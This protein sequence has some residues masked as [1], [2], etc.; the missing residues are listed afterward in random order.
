MEPGTDCT[1]NSERKNKELRGESWPAVEG[2]RWRY[3]GVIN[4]LSSE[5][6]GLVPHLCVSDRY[7]STVGLKER[8][9]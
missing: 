8:E 3:K 4:M 2:L 1:E 9:Q 7:L 6:V 5:R